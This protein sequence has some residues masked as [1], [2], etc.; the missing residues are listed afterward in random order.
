[1]NNLCGMRD[2][3]AVGSLASIISVKLYSADLTQSIFFLSA[4]HTG[5][6]GHTV[7]TMDVCGR[8][9]EGDCMWPWEAREQT[10][11]TNTWIL[12]ASST[13]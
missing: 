6:N 2:H 11:A 10:D 1:M 5:I 8:Q 13:S 3:H 12:V 4:N 7:H 9:K